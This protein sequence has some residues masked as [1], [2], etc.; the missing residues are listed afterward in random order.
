MDVGVT[1]KCLSHSLSHA[2]STDLIVWDSLIMYVI[3]GCQS[4]SYCSYIS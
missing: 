2:A 4:C 3:V 1:Q